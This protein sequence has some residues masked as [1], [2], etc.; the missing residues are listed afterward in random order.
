MRKLQAFKIRRFSGYQGAIWLL[1]CHGIQ[2][3]VVLRLYRR[4]SQ[5]RL[6][7]ILAFY[8]VRGWIVPLNHPLLKMDRKTQESL[9]KT[10]LSFSNA[11]S[12]LGV[13]GNQTL[14]SV[15]KIGTIS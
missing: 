13:L 4:A 2:A 5:T 15:P 11:D 9:S 1:I 7:I 12:I 14:A 3:A 8:D 6:T 10:D